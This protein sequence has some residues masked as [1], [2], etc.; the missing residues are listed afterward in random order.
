MQNHIKKF[1]DLRIF[2]CK[3]YDIYIKNRIFISK[4]RTENCQKH[5]KNRVKTAFKR[6]KKQKRRRKKN[7]EGSVCRKMEEQLVF[8]RKT[9]SRREGE[10]KNPN[11]YDENDENRERRKMEERFESFER[12][13][14]DF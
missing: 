5:A 7:D 3:T 2:F 10:L 11:G 4:I 8:C 13:K 9:E 6:I 12:K 1:C 14:V